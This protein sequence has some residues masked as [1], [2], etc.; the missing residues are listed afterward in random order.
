[1]LL[2]LEKKSKDR[3]FKK[4]PCPRQWYVTVVYIESYIYVKQYQVCG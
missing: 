4:V 1:M 2:L 3:F